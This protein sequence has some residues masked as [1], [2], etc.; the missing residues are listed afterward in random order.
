MKKDRKGNARKKLSLEKLQIS[1]IN[2][3][4]EITGGARKRKHTIVGDSCVENTI[5]WQEHAD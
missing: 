4:Q 3:P 5:L 2:T 1:K